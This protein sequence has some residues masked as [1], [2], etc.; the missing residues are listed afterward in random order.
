MNTKES[1]VNFPYTAWRL[2][3]TFKPVEVVIAR[4][5]QSWLISDQGKYLCSSEV[6]PTKAEAIE[7]GR[8]RIAVTE[9]DI[10]KREARIAK[11][12]AALDKAEKE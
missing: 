9:A 6:Y 3:P 10:T 7:D 4:R 11:K 2:T 8:K 5:S 12:R 1:V